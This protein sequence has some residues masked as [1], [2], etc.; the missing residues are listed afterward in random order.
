[1]AAMGVGLRRH[2]HTYR[3]FDMH[4]NF[5]I[6]PLC[7]PSFPT[8]G[9]RT[10]HFG[11]EGSGGVEFEPRKEWKQLPYFEPGGGLL[12]FTEPTPRP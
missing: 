5:E 9:G 2:F 7:V 4:W 8:S 3:H 12:I 6:V 1:M 11:G 10:Y